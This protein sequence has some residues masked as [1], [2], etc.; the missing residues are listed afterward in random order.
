MSVVAPTLNGLRALSTRIQFLRRGAWVADVVLDLDDTTV[1]GPALTGPATLIVGN[2]T[3]RGVFD[4]GR[5]SAFGPKAAARVVGGLGKGWDSLVTARHFAL[6]G[7]GLTTPAVYAATA[8]EIG[9]TVTDL[10]PQAL[11]AHWARVAG[12]A[13]NAFAGREW[14][15]DPLS[16]VTLVGLPWPTIVFDPSGVIVDLDVTQSR[17]SAISDSLILPGTTFADPRITGTLVASDVEQTFDAEGSRAEVWCT[18]LG[19]TSASRLLDAFASLARVTTQIDYART[20]RYRFVLPAG[21]PNGPMILQGITPGAP[22]LNP[23]EQW[24]GLAGASSAIAPGSEVVV[25]F[26]AGGSTDPYVVSYS[27][28]GGGAASLGVFLTTPLLTVTGAVACAG[29]TSTPAGGGAAGGIA[30][31]PLGVRL[32]GGLVALA[33]QPWASALATA[34]ATFAVAA[35]GGPATISAAATALAAAL[36]TLPPPGTTL[37]KGT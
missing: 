29:I 8:A 21:I 20:Y 5:S 26:T 16:G 30:A 27:P 11:G 22:D 28:L 13:S 33:T 36:G 4:A 32:D 35:E 7:G 23:I 34:L 6:P 12:P 31:T 19:A 9:E 18:P 24:T 3:L 25:G 10:A 1:Q 14:H 37:T 17:V 15:V 2:A